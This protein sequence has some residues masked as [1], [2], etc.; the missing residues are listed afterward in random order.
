[1]LAFPQPSPSFAEVLRFTHTVCFALPRQDFEVSGDLYSGD[2]SS[3]G[4]SVNAP[5]VGKPFA[6]CK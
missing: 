1:M 3:D 2:E 5:H 4:H 6:L